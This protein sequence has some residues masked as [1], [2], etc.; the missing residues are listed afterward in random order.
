MS[1]ISFIGVIIWLLFLNGVILLGTYYMAMY[2]STEVSLHKPIF[3]T[4][5]MVLVILTFNRYQR[6]LRLLYDGI[7]T[8][9]V[10][11]LSKELVKFVFISFIAY[12]NQ[13]LVLTNVTIMI[14]IGIYGLM[15]LLDT[16]YSYYPK[17]YVRK[18]GSFLD[19][20]QDFVNMK[21]YDDNNARN[22]ATMKIA[23]S[24]ARNS[25]GS[26]DSGETLAE[27]LPKLIV[28]TD[29]LSNDKS[30]Q[31]IKGLSEYC[32]PIVKSS[33]NKS[34]N[35]NRKSCY[36]IVDKLYSIS[37]KN[38]FH[39][40][41]ASATA[42]TV[43]E[44]DDPY[45]YES[46]KDDDTSIHSTDTGFGGG[47]GGK[48]KYKMPNGG[49][50]KIGFGGGGGFSRTH[51]KHDSDDD[52]EAE[53]D[54]LYHKFKHS[55]TQRHS[56]W[57]LSWLI[58]HKC[59]RPSV[60]KHLSKFN[61]HKASVDSTSSIITYTMDYGSTDLEAQKQ[62]FTRAE[63]D[64]FLSLYLRSA[65]FKIDFD[66][67]FEKYNQLISHLSVFEVL[68]LLSHR[69]I[70]NLLSLVALSLI[71]VNDHALPTVWIVL[72]LKLFNY[73][74]LNQLDT[75]LSYKLIIKILINVLAFG[76]CII[77]TSI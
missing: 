55:H 20:Y 32:L 56:P 76:V 4:L 71:Y 59:S 2:S 65:K 10:Y 66:P 44:V 15:T 23:E 1:L 6:M 54:D 47:G 35:S 41:T 19:V 67:I 12:N 75:K 50:I 43:N 16:I 21:S 70:W 8:R 14:I 36:N 77:Y 31:E 63:F 68:L 3:V 42:M 17:F 52:D 24:I 64:N 37:P 45:L 9:Y 58:P 51:P 74:Y 60:K 48:F 28:P 29:N 38:S 5:I 72:I 27:I 61:F 7:F 34:L 26:A 40:V 22:E 69:F 62:T 53:T 49:E 39:L 18:Y 33:S 46:P 57:N 13:G 30:D 73:N 25:V 11:P